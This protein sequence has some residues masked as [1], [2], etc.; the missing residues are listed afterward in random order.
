MNDVEKTGEEIISVCSFDDSSEKT[1][2]G[3]PPGAGRGPD[4]SPVEGD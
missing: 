3:R 1:G 4:I 2:G